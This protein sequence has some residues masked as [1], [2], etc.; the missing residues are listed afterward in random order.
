M[1]C[2]QYGIFTIIII[3]AVAGAAAIFILFS[4]SFLLLT[5]SP[6]GQC[7]CTK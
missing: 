4:G 6:V 3:G 5:T 2:L 7:E 1:S